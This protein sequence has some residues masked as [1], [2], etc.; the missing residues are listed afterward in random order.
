MIT[1]QVDKTGPFLITALPQ[2]IPVGFPFQSSDALL[3]LDAGA[4]GTGRDPAVTL[5]LGS[6]YT[7]TGGGYNSANQMQTGSITVVST[8]AHAV[9]AGDYITIMRAGALNQD[10]AFI[11][12]GPNSM[13]LLERMGDKL[14]TLDQ[15]IN[16]TTGR[17]LRVD[18][19]SDAQ[20]E[21]SLSERV[22]KLAGWDA[23]GDFTAYD[24]PVAVVA[25]G[26]V[27]F[28][29]SYAILRAASVA[30]VA[31]GTQAGVNGRATAGDGGGGVFYYDATSVAADDG[32]KV[33]RPTVGAGAWIRIIT[34][35]LNLAWFEGLTVTENNTTQSAGVMTA[36]GTALTTAINIL[37]TKGG[38]TLIFPTGFLHL[39]DTFELST[40][41][42]TPPVQGNG[43]DAYCFEFVGEGRATLVQNHA[44][45][46]LLRVYNYNL[47]F[48][49]TNLRLFGRGS[50]TTGS[51]LELAS[52][53]DWT[54][55]K[56]NFQ[57]TGGVGLMI[58]SA[59]RG[60]AYD[61]DFT[62]CR[63]AIKVC[64][65][66]N[67]CY[68]FNTRAIGCGATRDSVNEN[69]NQDSYSVN[70]SGVGDGIITAGTY[71][72]EKRASI[73]INGSQNVRFIGGSVKITSQLSGFTFKGGE[74][75]QM[76][77]FYFEGFG[78]SANASVIIG[79]SSIKTTTT[80]AINNAV[81][82][83]SLTETKWF[84]EDVSDDRFMYSAADAL[85]NKKYY[86]IYDPA[87]V[88]TFEVVTVRGFRNGAAVLGAR[89]VAGTAAAAWGSGVVF[90]EYLLRANQGNTTV[91]L[92]QNHLESYTG[93]PGTCVLAGTLA[94]GDTRGEI[95]V[96]KTYDEFHRSATQI[97]GSCV[98]NW[99]DNQTTV[100][101]IVN[102]G[103]MEGWFNSLIRSTN[104]LRLAANIVVAQID[105]AVA[106]C[107]PF[108]LACPAETYNNQAANNFP[109][110]MR[111]D[112]AAQQE[113]IQLGGYGIT[114]R[115]IG[116]QGLAFTFEAN[117]DDYLFAM[118]NTGAFVRLDLWQKIA[119]VWT[120]MLRMDTGGY[121][122][123][124]NYVVKARGAAVADAAG[125]ATVDA[126]ARA[127]INALLARCRVATGHGLIA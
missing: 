118:T 53:G 124:G 91:T 72:Q 79:G 80:G 111:F 40:A 66:A 125:G 20:D 64:Q 63:Q 70:R 47:K 22:S 50:A 41:T 14:A 99:I 73:E 5:T 54:L 52:A 105:P 48:T 114:T 104:N 122:V 1:S 8:G 24:I 116:R 49:A 10:T 36:N 11:P 127:A 92:Q 28:V 46:V 21:F 68:F 44:T 101:G 121:V 51:L 30:G 71:H 86:V 31:T 29:G 6:D 84:P 98:V 77:N 107:T 126:E 120:S 7:V 87:A 55:Q 15:Q 93:L 96:G 23:S 61:L 27:V 89:G 3:V 115:L 37:I 78:S 97:D 43:Y 109:S 39:S 117:K 56:M 102:G 32:W 18:K 16:E 69:N 13:S 95:V 34:S 90:R 65:I 75:L 38:G 88:A 42:I 82:S 85:A 57:S 9:I 113:G 17:C 83:V 119:G 112:D 2:V 26:D 45:K 25:S 19:T 76:D 62:Q 12:P 33:L 100:T 60:V 81:L 123:A 103:K 4:A 67:E 108:N 58:V 35:P 110:G 74:N 94:S 59:D 106:Q